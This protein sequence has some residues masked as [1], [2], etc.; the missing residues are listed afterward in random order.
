MMSASRIMCPDI[1]E[2]PWKRSVKTM[3][4]S[5]TAEALP[6]QSVGHLDLKAVAGRADGIQVDGLEGAPA[7]AF[8]A[9]GRIGERHAGDQRTYLA[10]QLLNNRRLSGQLM[11][12]MPL[13]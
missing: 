8:V 6:P 7:V 1:L 9:A 3:G 10:A 2:R 5:T 11:M 13:R 12:R 4:T